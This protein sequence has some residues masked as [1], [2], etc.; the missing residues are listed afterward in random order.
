MKFA[1]T[2]PN[3]ENYAIMK[4]TLPSNSCADLELFTRDHEPRAQMLIGKL[5]AATLGLLIRSIK[6]KRILEIGTFTGY[7][8]LAMAEHLPS[9]GEIHTIDIEKKEYTDKFWKSSPHFKKINFHLGQALEVIP[10]LKGTFDFIFIDA[11][12][13]NYLNYFNLT[14]K[15]LSS[16]GMIVVDNVLWDGKV[17]M[18]DNEL[19]NDKATLA[20]KEFNEMI[21][22]RNDLYKTLLPIRDGIFVITKK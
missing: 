21:Q 2:E 18:N 22:N 8:A 3:I 1:I 5:E 10:K 16:N 13:E 4:S 20:I 14:E 11:D 17:L 9:D 7:S 19:K 15:L 12:K 6:A